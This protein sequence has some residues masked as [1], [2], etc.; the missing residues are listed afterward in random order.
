[1]EKLK[2]LHAMLTFTTFRR[3]FAG[4]FKTLPGQFVCAPREWI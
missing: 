3:E 2:A 1:M 4:Q